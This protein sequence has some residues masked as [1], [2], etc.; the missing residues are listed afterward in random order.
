MKYYEDEITEEVR[1]QQNKL[2]GHRVHLMNSNTYSME[3]PYCGNALSYS[4]VEKKE[5]L[6]CRHSFPWNEE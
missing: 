3:C 5:C 2:N 4:D 1:K 6:H